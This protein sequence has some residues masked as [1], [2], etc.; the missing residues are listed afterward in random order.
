MSVVRNQAITRKNV[1]YSDPRDRK[2][3]IINDLNQL[4]K[5]TQAC[6]SMLPIRT[7]EG[8]E[9]HKNKFYGKVKEGLESLQYIESP[10]TIN[11]SHKII[12]HPINIKIS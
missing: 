10:N 9:L 4:S 5:D 6:Y 11:Q 1:Y 12:N 7:K 3:S 8:F 2:H